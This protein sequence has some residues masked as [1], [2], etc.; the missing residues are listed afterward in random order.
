M[1]QYY[2]IILY[3]LQNIEGLYLTK[4]LTKCLKRYV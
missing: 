1:Y 4:G 3:V 2:Y